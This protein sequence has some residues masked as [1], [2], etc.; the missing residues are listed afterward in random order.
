MNIHSRYLE[1]YTR[2]VW[3]PIANTTT[4]H[5]RLVSTYKHQL[6]TSTTIHIQHKDDSESELEM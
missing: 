1:G 5:A 4:A 2:K 3:Q 6:Q